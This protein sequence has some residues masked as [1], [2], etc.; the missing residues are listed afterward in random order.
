MLCRKKMAVGLT[1]VAGTTAG[2]AVATVGVP[3]AL[4]T[5]GFTAAGI[6]GLS[7]IGSL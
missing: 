7:C 4:G 6:A 5:I 3:A 1:A 2:L